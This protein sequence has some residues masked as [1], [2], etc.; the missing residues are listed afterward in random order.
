MGLLVV[1]PYW[2]I[3]SKAGFSGW[4]CLTQLVPI[5]NLIAFFYWAFAEWPIQRELNRMKQ[6]SDG[7]VT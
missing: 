7:T 3:F 6:G 4:F 2:K 5:I 1:L